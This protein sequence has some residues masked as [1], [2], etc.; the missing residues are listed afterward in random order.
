MKENGK[1]IKFVEMVVMFGLMEDNILEDG[2][3]IICTGKVFILG[4]ME[5]NMK[6]IILMIKKMLYL[7]F[8]FFIF[9]KYR[10][11][12]YIVGLMAENM[13]ENGKTENKA[14]KENIFY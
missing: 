6:E 13:K 4:K 11:S 7:C 12:E 3:I 5:G 2:L 9:L 8:F 1:I 14:G 10:D